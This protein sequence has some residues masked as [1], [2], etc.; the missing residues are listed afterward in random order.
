MNLDYY[1]MTGMQKLAYKIKQGAKGFWRGFCGFWI[2]LGKGFVGFFASIFKEAREIISNF[3][4]GNS[5][6]KVSY[7]FMGFGHIFRGQIIRGLIYLSLELL[8]IGYM[9]LFGD[10]FFRC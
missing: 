8:F 10:A 2:G 3:R 6:T 5:V 9:L 7:L 1:K 4:Y